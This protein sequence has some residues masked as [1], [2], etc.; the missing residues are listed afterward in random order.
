MKRVLLLIILCSFNFLFGQDLYK[1][2]IYLQY[3]ADG[4]GRKICESWSKII[5]NYEDG[6]KE[7]VMTETSTQYT[8]NLNLSKPKRINS[9]YFEG[10]ARRKATSDIFGGCNGDDENP[11]KTII[12]NNCIVS[13]Y[14][15]SG[16]NNATSISY[17][18]STQQLPI[19]SLKTDVIDNSQPTPLYN[20]YLPSDD[21]I[22]IYDKAGFSPELYHYQYTL[23]PEDKSSWKDINSSLYV[24]EKLSVTG[25]D[26]FGADYIN[27]IGKKVYF[28]AVSCPDANGEYQSWSEPLFLTLIQSAPHIQNSTISHPLCSYSADGKVTL[29]FDRKLFTGETL[30]TVLIDKAT[31]SAIN[32]YDLTD[33][34]QNSTQYTINDLDAG[35]YILKLSR[36]SYQGQP[37]YTDSPTHNIEFIITK[38]TPVKYT[39]TSQKNINCFGGSDGAINLSASGGQNKYQYSLDS[40]VNWVDFNNG[41]STSIT[42]L[43]AGT[44]NILVRDSNGCTAKD[45]N[46]LDKIEKVTLSQPSAPIAINNTQIV[47]PTGYGLS[48]GYISVRVEGGTPNTDKSYYYEWRKD[49]PTGTVMPAGQITTDAQNNPFTI[50]LDQLPAGKYYLTVKD[51]NY[52]SATSAQTACGIISQ[53]FIVE[54]PEPLIVSIQ[55]QKGISC[56]SENDDVYKNNIE[57]DKNNNGV[58]DLFEDGSL[59]ALAKGGVG[60][61]AYQWQ[62]EINGAYQDI[63]GQTTTDLSNLTEGKYKI[64]VVDKNQ[65]KAEAE[66]S[67]VFPSQL[68]LSVQ[69]STV[70]CNS[71]N[72]GEVSVTPFGGSGTYTYSWTNGATTPTV[73][74]LSAGVYSVL[75]S[76]TN[77]CTIKGTA[78][79]Q[80]PELLEISD[81]SINNPVCFGS[82]NGS[83]QIK[84]SGGKM[85]YSIKWSN[86]MIGEQISGLKAGSYIVTFTDAN[87]CS[88]SKEYTL[89]EPEQRVINLGKDITLCAGDSQDY[90]ISINDAG[91]IY[92]WMDQIGKII[93]T[94]PK[95][96]LSIAGA[97]TAIVTDSKGCSASDTITIRN[98]SEILNPQFM[99]ATHAYTEASVKL[100]NTSPT[101]PQSVEWV[102]PNEPSIQIIEK[103][104]DYLEVKFSN[105]GSYQFGLKGKQGECEKTFYKDV[106]VEQNLSGVELEPARIS[107]IKEFTIVPNP[108]QGVYK[109]IVKLYEEADIKIRLMDM[110]S[111]EPF[112]PKT[113][114]KA[115]EFEVPFNY[116]IPSGTYL[117]ILETQ[118]EALVKKMIVQ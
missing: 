32:N 17:K 34:L 23:T 12:L 28:R 100:V 74:G 77:K 45:T 33:S 63:D 86:G 13:T 9:V 101:K 52:E 62:K 115:T 66:F 18:I 57:F 106:I 41:S 3:K 67:L 91:A 22:N 58:F 27:H 105:T 78:T 97:Y 31:N 112:A 8:K 83:I 60:N 65:N 55:L 82:A 102:I 14:N 36:G 43:S 56:N 37:T 94:N 20:T 7:E 88:I 110:I 44:Y 89:I 47:Q 26:L 39:V 61:Y 79:V 59:A 25:K 48:N 38:P 35:E 46:N 53:E 76:D 98:S 50:K 93:S 92:Q 21:K 69:G 103:N 6:T 29:D 87:G 113:L 68:T 107:N 40:G 111:H 85:P 16:D 80:Q 81:I 42:G 70:K 51:A 117:I 54:Q 10:Y 24:N 1:I 71:L 95:I 73:T 75:V 84:V 15:D 96:S 19:H 30:Q 104:D 2:N 4:D 5:L 72:E 109:V 99:I 90:D 49:S 116:Q 114:S 108:N 11:K 118:D 64:L